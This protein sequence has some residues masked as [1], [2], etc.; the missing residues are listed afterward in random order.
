T[1][2]P[3]PTGYRGVRENGWALIREIVKPDRIQKEQLFHTVDD[4]AETN[5][6]ADADGAILRQ[7]ARSY[8]RLLSRGLEGEAATAAFWALDE[9]EERRKQLEALGYLGGKD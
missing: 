2:V 6:R 5:D 7:L 9:D 1:A 4:P 3:T 8:D